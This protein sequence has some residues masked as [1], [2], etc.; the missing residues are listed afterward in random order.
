MVKNLRTKR[1]LG[2]AFRLRLSC[3]LKRTGTGSK[4]A[5][6]SQTIVTVAV[7]IHVGKFNLETALHGENSFESLLRYSNFLS[8]SQ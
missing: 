8:N 6:A 5:K 7:A 1:L 4:N 3:T 2:K